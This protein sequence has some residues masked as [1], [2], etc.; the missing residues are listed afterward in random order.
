MKA[1]KVNAVDKM[2]FVQNVIMSDVFNSSNEFA[3]AILQDLINSA[4][5]E[6]CTKRVNKMD[7]VSR[8]NGKRIANKSEVV[9]AMVQEFSLDEDT[10]YGAYAR[11]LG[12]KL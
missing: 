7:Q 9:K 2:L 6:M 11:E 8:K 4:K 10:I 5:K 3:V 1:N 12:V